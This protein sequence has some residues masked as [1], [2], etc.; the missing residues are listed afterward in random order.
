M[1]ELDA[2][3][4]QRIKGG[5]KPAARMERDG[6]ELDNRRAKNCELCSHRAGEDRKQAATKERFFDEPSKQNIEQEPVRQSPST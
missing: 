2:P 5:F 3:R 1:R 6:L 4:L